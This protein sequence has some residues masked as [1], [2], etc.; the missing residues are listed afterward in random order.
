MHI[1][2]AQKLTQ[3]RCAHFYLHQDSGMCPVIMRLQPG[4][5]AASCYH[6]RPQRIAV[7]QEAAEQQAS[8]KEL[9]L[10]RYSKVSCVLL[11]KDFIIPLVMK[12][13]HRKEAAEGALSRSGRGNSLVIRQDWQS[14]S[15]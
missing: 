14:H 3:V 5:M 4:R 6:H 13:G 10:C 12:F 1:N 9:R 8:R 15:I 2:L 7:T 11:E